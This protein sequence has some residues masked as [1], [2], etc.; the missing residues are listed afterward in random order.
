MAHERSIRRLCSGYALLLRLYPKRYRERFAEPMGQV[1][2]DLL[3]E[4]ARQEQSLVGF[5]VRMFGETFVATIRENVMVMVMQNTGI[6]RIAL[7]TALMLMVPFI[8]MQYTD[9]VNWS[10]LDFVVAGALLFSAGLT[11]HLVARRA[12]NIAYRIAIGIAVATALLLVWV[13]LAVGIIGSENN[14]ANLMYFGVLTVG[15]V[16]ALIARFQPRGMA[17]ALLATAIAQMLVAALALIAKLDANASPPLEVFVL[18]GFFA[19]LWIASSLLF[20]RASI[21]NAA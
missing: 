4:R 14:P 3:R 2:N 12:G 6:I 11:Y 1:F 10:L 19:T 16:G 18:N 21:Q 13:N 7:A 8:A 5:A 20:R 15:F 9:E 17:G